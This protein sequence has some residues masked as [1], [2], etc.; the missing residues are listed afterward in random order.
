MRRFL[1]VIGLVITCSSGGFIFAQNKPPL[2]VRI[3]SKFFTESVILGEIIAQLLRHNGVEAIHKQGLGGTTFLWENLQNGSIDIYPEYTGTITQELLK[4]Q[5]IAGEDAIRNALDLRQIKMSRPLGF[6]DTYAIGMPESLA[7]EKG[8]RTIS[9]LRNHPDLKFGFTNEFLNRG[10]GWLSLKDR[11][12]LPQRDVRGMEHALAY[13]AMQAGAIQATDLYTTDPE[14]S[15][16]DLRVLQDDKKHFPAYYAV[17]LYRAD[18]EERA[19]DVVKTILQ[20]EGRISR[21][22]ILEMNAKAKPKSGERIS[23]ARLAADFLSENP[24]FF[25]PDE[26]G[27]F[28][29]P[30]EMNLIK[31][32]L[33]LTW[34][35]LLLVASSLVAAVLVSVPLGVL[36]YRRPAFGQFILGG[37][38]II[39]TIPSLA[40]LVLLIPL[41]K[42]IG[43]DYPPA[44]AALFLYSLLPIVRNTY[45]GLREIAVPI[46]ESAEALGLP[47]RARLWLVELPLASPAVLAGIKTS[48]VINVGTATL[49]GLI[50]AGGYGEPIFTGI[51]LNNS[52]ITME[53]AIPAALMA[54]AV[55]GLFELAERAVVPRGLRLRPS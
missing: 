54:L 4:C 18:L 27:E 11:Y 43:T 53:G 15:Y 16:Y 19:P 5:G 47:A 50:G 9:D 28:L 42:D 37:V 41:L 33:I 8:I 20:L 25:K 29:A 2:S 1:S 30:P 24:F 44:I 35:H 3:G 26:S 51:R 49:G 40:L 55:Q 13:Q 38:G 10:D 46:R 39:Q 7:R 23:E 31:R 22:A 52:A 48:A 6:N 32:L 36:A 17:L 12:E 45:T 14:I 34:Q 21:A